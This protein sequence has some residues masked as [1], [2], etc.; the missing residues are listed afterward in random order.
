MFFHT[1]TAECH[2]A[3]SSQTSGKVGTRLEIHG[4]L[5]MMLS[6][7]MLLVLRVIFLSSDDVYFHVAF[8]PLI[9]VVRYGKGC[10]IPFI[11]PSL[12]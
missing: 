2:A 9:L 1:Y 5:L 11:F 10:R 4:V 12:C 6:V 8:K 7:E 3:N